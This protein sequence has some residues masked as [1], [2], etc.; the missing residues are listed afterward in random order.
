MFLPKNVESFEA[1]YMLTCISFSVLLSK[2]QQHAE[3]MKSVVIPLE[4][5][6]KLLKETNT[7]VVEENRL[8]HNKV[9]VN[10]DN[11]SL[12]ILFTYLFQHKYYTLMYHSKSFEKATHQS[13]KDV[14]LSNW[15]RSYIRLYIIVCK[16]HRLPLLFTL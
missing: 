3:V 4:D 12:L 8:L 5:E 6:I 10:I 9:E 11:D 16:L 14:I 2:A 15:T 13:L 7:K 1:V